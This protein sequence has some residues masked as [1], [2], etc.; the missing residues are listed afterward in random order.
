MK[1]MRT[2]LLCLLVLASA[3]TAAAD[4]RVKALPEDDRVWLEE[5]VVYI[6]T[7]QERNVFLDLKTQEE[8]ERFQQAFWD[9]RD[10]NPATKKN[11]FMEEH[12]RRLQYANSVLGRDSTRPGWK[13][14]RGRFY[15]ILGKPD[16][17]QQL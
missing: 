13:T 1:T 16:E 11:E 7:P 6:I 8:R 3:V 2:K 5:E 12:Y 14:D 9:R 17:I 4:D 15:I 10:P